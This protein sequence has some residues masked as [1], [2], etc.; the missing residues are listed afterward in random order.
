MSLDKPFTLLFSFSPCPWH[1]EF[2]GPGIEPE[3]EQW[4]HRVLNHK[5]PRELHKYFTFHFPHMFQVHPPRCWRYFNQP[6]FSFTNFI[7]SFRSYISVL[8]FSLAFIYKIHGEPSVH[9]L[10]ITHFIGAQIY[11]GLFL[12]ILY[13]TYFSTVF[14]C[15]F[16]QMTHRRQ[17]TK[18]NLV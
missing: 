10:F 15:L 4:Q 14:F 6:F 13:L 3:P 5:S 11:F 8:F 12:R 18:A 2:P 9:H 7:V 16:I 17:Y 1:A